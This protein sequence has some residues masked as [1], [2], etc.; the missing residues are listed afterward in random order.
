[1]NKTKQKD[2]NTMWKFW[3][4][5]LLRM[6]DGAEGG[7][8]LTNGVKEP[9]ADLPP[10]GDNDP[11]FKQQADG[12]ANQ[13]TMETDWDKME[14]QTFED[15]GEK[16]D[17]GKQTGEEKEEETEGKVGEEEEIKL[18]GE[19]GE[20]DKGQDKDK[21]EEQSK[22]KDDSDPSKKSIEEQQPKQENALDKRFPEARIFRKKMDSHARQYFD[23]RLAEILE[24]EV[25]LSEQSEALKSAQA[26]IPQIPPS[27][28]D[29]EAAIVLTPQFQQST[30]NTNLAQ[31]VASHWDNQMM[32]IMNGDPW[33][34]LK[35]VKDESGRV[36]DVAPSDEEFEAN[37]ANQH[38]VGKWLRDSERQL[39]R[40]TAQQEFLVENFQ[41][42]V[43][44]R[45]ASITEATN[46]FFPPERWNNQ[47]DPRW[48]LQQNVKKGLKN[49]GITEANP[50]FDLMSKL[51]AEVLRLREYIA[52]QGKTTA[53]K[54]EIEKKQERAGPTGKSTASGGT[55]Q[56]KEEEDTMA[57][58][59]RLLNKG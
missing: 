41:K 58:F 21:E 42:Q 37:G 28:Y 8:S 6:P 53:K 2:N 46:K 18:G 1:M 49:I 47:K 13:Q 23:A 59:N 16:K 30:F 34:K 17:D 40:F 32:K 7:V 11:F 15:T 9:P 5:N 56:A 24:K 3:N 45:I 43:Q 51:G 20:E 54:E 36:I 48:E 14:G 4:I 19:D 26:G 25:E 10:T 52:G 29:N 22:Q 35:Y 55:S 44:H 38:Q 31:K 50:A 33:R 27:Y 57:S 12:N 39:E